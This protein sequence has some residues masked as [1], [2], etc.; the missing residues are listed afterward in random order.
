M[1]E[2]KKKAKEEGK[3]FKKATGKRKA[4]ATG[5]SEREDC[6]D[7][8]ADDATAETEPT[9]NQGG[10]EFGRG[11]H[12]AKKKKVTV[13]TVAMRFEPRHVLMIKSRR[14]MDTSKEGLT[15]GDDEDVRVELDLHAD[16]CV[17]GSN[18]VVLDLTGKVVSVEPFCEAEYQSMQDIPVATVATA[19]DCS[20]TGKVHILVINEALYF[21]DKM[22]NTLL[23]PNQLR[24]N[25]IQVN[26]CPKQF[27][28]TSRHSLLIPG[29]DEVE[30]PLSMRGVI[31]GFTTRLPTQSEL[32][33]WASHVELTSEMEWDPHSTDF[34]EV[35]EAHD[36]S[37]K[38]RRI[39]TVDTHHATF[40]DADT[41][42]EI[43]LAECNDLQ[44]R[45]LATVRT[46]LPSKEPLRTV[47]AVIRSDA[48]S[49]ITPEHLA[50]AWN[51]GLQTATKTLKVTTQ[52]GVRAIKHPAQ[53]RF[54]TAM[55]HLRY[56]RL[57]GTWYA[58]TLF[59]STKSVRSFECAHL[60]G[61]GIGFAH[62]TPMESK[63]DAFLSL[64]G[65]IRTH[66]VMETLVVDN[67]PTMAFKEWKHTVREFRINQKNTEPYSPWQNK[68]ELDVREVK[69]G[70]RR[71]KRRTNS[72][73][74]LWCFLGELVTALR[75]FTAYESSKLQGRYTRWV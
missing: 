67:D 14:V 10:N 30:I 24:A 13:S 39:H 42:V 52:L 45:L 11:A 38:E 74:R 6:D 19:Y 3:S 32:D 73:R 51:I 70:I 71:F 55:P 34:S 65:F 56:P 72:P 12:A 50:K 36:E 35:E 31:S 40:Q 16:T 59:F 4:A 63:A 53:R 60:I 54:R 75:G 15:S 37:W 43:A 68:A 69:R 27:D 25:G 49:V 2:L 17:A 20:V 47:Q 5:S 8:E 44:S 18:T 48:R 22:K 66:G 46:E 61:N 64:D 26:D 21:G 57:M 23:N 29:K 58:D 28:P 62:F 41:L 1:I 7:E 9:T 33:D